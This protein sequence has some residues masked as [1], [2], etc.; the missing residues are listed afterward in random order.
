MIHR[1]NYLNRG[2][3]NTVRNLSTPPDEKAAA[4]ELSENEKKLA[5]EIESL[6]KDVENYKEKCVDLDVRTDMFIVVCPCLL[7]LY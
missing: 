6:T 5:A 2:S 7:T 4:P 3:V 1:I